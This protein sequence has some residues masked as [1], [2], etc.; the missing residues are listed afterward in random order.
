[1]EYIFLRLTK[2]RRFFV[3]IPRRISIVATR[4]K[5]MEDRVS[6]SF[7]AKRAFVGGEIVPLRS[8]HRYVSGVTA[9]R[10]QSRAIAF[11]CRASGRAWLNPYLE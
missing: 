8:F 1:M 3:D 5:F 6:A 11:P 7:V 10:M 2:H 9:R 4:S